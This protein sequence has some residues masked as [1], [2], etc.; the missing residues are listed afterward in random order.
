MELS[1]SLI[2]IALFADAIY[3]K[4]SSVVQLTASNFD[5][6]VLKSEDFWIVEFFSPLCGPCQKLIPDYENAA[7]SLKGIANLGV[8]DMTK[9][10]ILGQ[11]YE[12]KKYPTFKVF[13]ANKNKPRDYTGEKSAK[14]FISF[15]LRQLE[16]DP[17]HNST[18]I[19]NG[20]YILNDTNFESTVIKSKDPWI[21]NFYAPWCFYS[22]QLAPE[23]TKAADKLKT[24]IKIGKIDAIENLEIATRFKISEYPSIRIFPPNSKEVYESISPRTA[25][26]IVKAVYEKL[27]SYGIPM[28]IVQLTSEEIL[29]QYCEEKF[30]IIAFL[31]H[32]YDSSA[33][34]RQ[35]YLDMLQELI[36]KNRGKSVSFLWAQA[37]DYYDL[38]KLFGIGM[39][40]PAVVGLALKYSSFAP[41]KGSFSLQELNLFVN[42]FLVGG[43]SLE[44]F[45]ELPLIKNIEPWDG[46]DQVADYQSED[47]VADY[48][49]EDQVVDYQSEDL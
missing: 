14:S 20:V 34:E 15:V 2:F 23:W 3:S 24:I 4:S 12:I 29:A 19:E 46:K 44:E 39:G 36:K 30:C 25:E 10:Y 33:E 6:E 32:I 47:Q 38:E 1:Y 40:Y 9:D 48:Q 16:K 43:F 18:T 27:E 41:M 37:G 45:N 8:V 49:S 21:V 28:P 5:S 22:K 42:R 26:S 17:L 13:S 35:K 31:P 7:E 11:T